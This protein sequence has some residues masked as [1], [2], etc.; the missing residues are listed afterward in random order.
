MAKRDKSDDSPTRVDKVVKDDKALDRAG[1][2]SQ[3]PKGKIEKEL[4]EWAD[5]ID[6]G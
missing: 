3:K 2:R 4:R 6:K 5:D 1:D